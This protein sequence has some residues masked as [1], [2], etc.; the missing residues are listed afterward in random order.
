MSF[1]LPVSTDP[2]IIK[3]GAKTFYSAPLDGHAVLKAGRKLTSDTGFVYNAGDTVAV[4]S[5]DRMKIVTSNHGT[6]KLNRWETFPLYVSNPAQ[7]DVAAGKQN[8]YAYTAPGIQPARVT[9]RNEGQTS[10]SYTN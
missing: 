10:T 7:T 3:G 8:V 1:P 2:N 4:T 9:Y 5:F 6:I